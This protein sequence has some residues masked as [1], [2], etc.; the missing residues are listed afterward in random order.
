MSRAKVK[1]WLF[2]LA[3]SD[4]TYNHLNYFTL[5]ITEPQI[6]SKFELVWRQNFL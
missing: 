4:E 3:Y 2:S 6:S 1:K 5:K